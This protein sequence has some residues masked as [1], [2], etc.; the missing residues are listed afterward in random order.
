MYD[1]SGLYLLQKSLELGSY[2]KMLM[3]RVLSD[4]YRIT[5]DKFQFHRVEIY[6]V[7]AYTLYQMP[8]TFD[9]GYRLKCYLYFHSVVLEFCLY[10]IWLEYV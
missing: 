4:R 1:V 9:K 5:Q 3:R 7:W 8:I 6:D 2:V 10:Y